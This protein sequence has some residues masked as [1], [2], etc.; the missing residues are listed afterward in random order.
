M[1]D[2]IEVTQSDIDHA[3]ANKLAGNCTQCA[4]ARALYRTGYKQVDVDFTHL[5]LDGQWY[6]V[7]EEV[8]IWQEDFVDRQNAQ[9]FSF[10]IS[11][12][13]A[14]TPAKGSW[15]EEYMDRK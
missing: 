5:Y 3:K 11:D 9:P 12:L 13:T 14:I 10:K 6:R 2:L 1:S 15:R 7:T 4:I 8:R